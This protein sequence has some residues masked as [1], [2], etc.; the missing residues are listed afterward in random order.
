MLVYT[1]FYAICISLS[2]NCVSRIFYN[3]T[4]SVS[5][6]Y[7]WYNLSYV[8]K[9]FV[10]WASSKFMFFKANELIQ[11]CFN[12]IGIICMHFLNV[13]VYLGKEH[14][15]SKASQPSLKLLRY[16]RDTLFEMFL[17][18][19]PCERIKLNFDSLYKAWEGLM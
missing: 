14:I 1:L 7:L 17:C 9:N 16:V 10:N 11:M 19:N 2:L 4:S 8:L 12:V 18:K 3:F 5:L 15:F 6:K 13:F